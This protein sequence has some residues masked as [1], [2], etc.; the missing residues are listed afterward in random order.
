MIRSRSCG[1]LDP[2]RVCRYLVVRALRQE[3]TG[4]ILRLK[5]IVVVD[6]RRAEAD[7]RPAGVLRAHRADEQL[8]IRETHR[9]DLRLAGRDAECEYA[10]AIARV[11]EG[12]TNR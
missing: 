8:V 4:P 11:S 9:G 1:R 12:E 7:E 10:R 6:P 2:G 5:Q 3:S